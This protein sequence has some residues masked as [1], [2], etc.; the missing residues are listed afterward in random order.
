MSKLYPP[1]IESSLP[2]F[3]GSVLQVPFQLNRAVSLAQVNR[4]SFII[5]TSTTGTVIVD[6]VLGDYVYNN[7]SYYARLDL[8][9]INTKLRE[10]QYYKIQIAF[11][12]KENN[13]GYY[14]T[15]G[16]IK[17]TTRPVLSI[18]DITSNMHLKEYV[19]Q[20]DQRDGDGTEKIYSY[21][22]IIRDSLGETYDTSGIQLHNSATDIEVDQ[23]IDTWRPSK[24][25]KDDSVYSIEYSI[26][27]INGLQATTGQL[28]ITMKDAVP[29]NLPFKLI[30]VADYEEGCNNVYLRPIRSKFVSGDYS[31][32]RTSS[33]ED[34]DNWIELY[35]FAYDGYYIEPRDIFDPVFDRKDILIFKD[36]TTAQ[37]FSYKYCIQTH[38]SNGLYSKRQLNQIEEIKSY[39]DGRFMGTFVPE[40]NSGAEI[41]AD[42]EDMF[43]YDGERQLKIRFNPKV[44]SFKTTVLESKM[45]TLGGKYPFI[46]RNGNVE[47]KEFSIAGLLSLVAD[48]ANTFLNGVNHQYYLTRSGTPANQ[49]FT[50]TFMTD[51]SGINIHQE[52]KFKLAVLDWLNNGKPKLFRSPTEGNY[53]VQLMSTSLTPN[54][55][56]GRMLHSFT[57]Q[58]CEIDE[59]SYD[60]LVSYGFVN[61]PYLGYKPFKVAQLSVESKL[62]EKADGNIL[63]LPGAYYLNFTEAQEFTTIG[64]DF[65]DGRGL[66]SI[67]IGGTG[68]YYVQNSDPVLRVELQSGT[69]EDCGKITYCYYGDLENSDFGAIGDIE[70]HIEIRQLVGEDFETNIL[71]SISDIR[72]KLSKF[73]YLKFQQRPIWDIYTNDNKTYY[74]TKNLNDEIRGGDWNKV[75]IYRVY[76]VSGE[77]IT[78]T[79]WIYDGS[80]PN[81]L[82]ILSEDESPD[83]SV[84]IY[85]DQILDFGGNPDSEPVTGGRIAS[86]TD[87]DTIDCLK[88]GNGVVADVSY[89][90]KEI[91]YTVE[92]TN[93]FIKEVKDN[94]LAKKAIWEESYEDE[95]LIIMELAYKIYIDTLT[96][97]IEE[98]MNSED[99]I[100]DL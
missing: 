59:C 3:A 47:F 42:F 63:A 21:C 39:A 32:C 72:R 20:Y 90:V 35:N 50:T 55:T 51:L 23:S 49:D 88:I 10:G 82:D 15:V 54:D 5:K 65:S 93:Q 13:I 94:Y 11:T 98:L 26:T 96:P 46:F 38:N 77:E 30:V 8:N 73:Y 61:P 37:G 95:D 89:S 60:N 71:E 83:Y 52:R 86:F 85:K 24:Q 31:L 75:T 56:L 14:S 78:F 74:Y 67:S 16:I 1:I 76:N 100:Y 18:P 25:L 99:W 2:A 48:S 79:G 40:D 84:S 44:A 43:L 27:T 91:L 12:D 17:Y 53:I 7:G 28:P 87:I 70:T 66:V 62:L 92:E 41:F 22:F 58:A 45:N 81:E 80:D 9:L 36:Y 68:C 29:I 33:D 69:W 64:L 57:S 4:I 6:S 34:F 97:V 19:G